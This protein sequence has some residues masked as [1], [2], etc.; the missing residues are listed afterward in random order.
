MGAERARRWFLQKQEDTIVDNK[1]VSLPA[2]E[3]RSMSRQ[4]TTTRTFRYLRGGAVKVAG[5][6]GWAGIRAT[7]LADRRSD[8]HKSLR[9]GDAALRCYTW[10]ILVIY[11]LTG[12]VAKGLNVTGRTELLCTH[13][14]STMG[15]NTFSTAAR[16]CRVQSHPRCFCEGL[17]SIT[18]TIMQKKHDY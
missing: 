13:C 16:L 9:S 17:R 15:Q 14:S 8:L 10:T 1:W 6:T 3:L 4:A 12:R 18:V 2:G 5:S 11:E 7:S